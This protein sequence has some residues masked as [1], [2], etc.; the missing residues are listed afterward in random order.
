MHKAEER[1]EGVGPFQLS[2]ANL[3]GAYR[4]I[5]NMNAANSI[6]TAITGGYER[7]PWY[8]SLFHNPLQNT[9]WVGP[10]GHL[11]VVF[12]SAGDVVL[13]S[14]HEGTFNFFSPDNVSGHVTADVAPYLG[15]LLGN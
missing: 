1:K 5:L 12:N 3:D 11:E 4:N 7:Q 9:K 14:P 13:N 15:R 8:K 10:Y 2:N 6:A